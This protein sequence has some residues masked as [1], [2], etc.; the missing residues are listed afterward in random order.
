MNEDENPFLIGKQVTGDKFANRKKELELIASE[1][2]SGQNVIIISPRRFGKTSLVINALQTAGLNYSY[3]DC[4]LAKSEEGLIEQ[5]LSSFAARQPIEKVAAALKKYLRETEVTLELAP[6]KVAIKR[7][8]HSSLEETLKFISPNP[9]V[10]DEFQDVVNINENLPKRLRGVIQHQKNAY[11]FMG[12]KRHMMEDIFE[13]PNNPFYKSG[14]LLRLELIPP[15][16]FKAFIEGWFEKTGVKLRAKDV[17]S[18]LDF[19]AGHPYYTQYLSHVLWGKRRNGNAQGV[20][21]MIAEIVAL[22]TAFYESIYGNLTPNQ[23]MALSVIAQE[24]NVFSMDSLREQ[25]IKSTQTM[26]SAIESLGNKEIIDKNSHYYFTDLFF[27]Q[28]VLHKA[29]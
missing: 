12:S 15:S 10:L 7:I 19:T 6:I 2:R 11:F 29:G 5:L 1:A 20:G 14:I 16:D 18:I 26:Q 25:G 17:E 24:K 3:A 9:V 8:G 28:W 22:N 27:K 21:E 23:K 13:N 4:S